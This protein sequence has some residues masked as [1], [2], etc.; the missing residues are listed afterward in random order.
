MLCLPRSIAL[1]HTLEQSTGFPTQ[2]DIGASVERLRCADQPRNFPRPEMLN[3]RDEVP[4]FQADA[5][6]RYCEVAGVCEAQ[7]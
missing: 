1:K 2:R 4:V 3:K 6:K 5:A 7:E